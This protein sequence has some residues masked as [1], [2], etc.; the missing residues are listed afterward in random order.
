MESSMYMLH[1]SLGSTWGSMVI[2]VIGT[3]SSPLWYAYHV[4]WRN[5]L[6]GLSPLNGSGIASHDCTTSSRI[7]K[8]YL[9]TMESSMYMLQR[10]LGSTWGSMVINVI[11][12]HSSPLWYAYHVLWRNLLDGLSPL[13]G[14]GIASHDCTT[15]SRIS[16]CYLATIETSKFTIDGLLH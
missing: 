11:G 15:S 4:L 10:P 6:D 2:N 3:H 14:S 12:T 9:A 5:L 8:C 16:N 1:Q 13:N 7:S